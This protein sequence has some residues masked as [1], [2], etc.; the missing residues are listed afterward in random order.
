MS[1]SIWSPG[2]YLVSPI[3][4]EKTVRTYPSPEGNFDSILTAFSGNIAGIA[5]AIS[6]SITGAT[7]LTQPITGYKY[8]QG[9]Y[10]EVG[11]LYNSSG[12]NQSLTGNVGRT[13][14]VYKYI[15]VDQYGQGDAVG[16][17]VNS[18]AFVNKPGATNFL[19]QPAIVCFNGQ[20]EAFANHVHLNTYETLAQD[21]GFDIACIGIVNNLNRT[22]AGGAQSAVWI[23]YRI[24]STGSQP[25]NSIISAVGKANN[26]LD[27][28]MSGLDFGVNQSAISLKANQRI[29]FNNNANASG[30][31]NADFTTTGYNQDYITYNSVT[32][33]IN[34]VRGGQVKVDVGFFDVAINNTPLFITAYGGSLTGIIPER[35]GPGTLRVVTQGNQNCIIGIAQSVSI[36]PILGFP[37]G[38]TG[39]G[40]LIAGGQGNTAF[41][42]YFEG[43]TYATRGTICGAEIDTFN[44]GGAPTTNFPPDRSIGTL[45]Q[46]PTSITVGAGGTFQSHT[47][48]YICREGSAPNSFLYGIGIDAN[49]VTEWGI[50]I[51]ATSGVGPT[52]PLLVK[53]K[54]SAIGIQIQAI[55]TPTAGNSVL[56]VVN[57]SSA[58]T[59]GIRQDG[60]I[61]Y[62][63]ANLQ[64]TVGAAGGASAL[65]LTPLGYL[66]VVLESGTE[67]AVPYYNRV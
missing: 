13:A 29:Y 9:A 47:G 54:T 16:I 42:A 40:T 28:S 20:Q 38:V 17:H 61:R 50:I 51:D 56:Q 44:Y 21:N 33:K 39:L 11:Y 36:A 52:L 64:T 62:A 19:A 58:F 27:F 12:H 15:K 18:N 41:G 3:F 63:T 37:T 14:A 43:I 8:V 26:G 34:I 48:I 2:S 59:F 65:P 35:F 55:G 30:P 10:P 60:K 1:A 6:H 7:T 4:I 53:H 22:N 67:V 25:I 31:T 23:G 46:S 49:A 57:T 5:L 45:Q 66:R 24:Q 32:N